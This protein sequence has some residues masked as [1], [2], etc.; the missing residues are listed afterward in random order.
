MSII[1]GI[2]IATPPPEPLNVNITT[3]LLELF[4]RSLAEGKKH[5]AK[6]TDMTSEVRST[7]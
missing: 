6:S 4:E 2:D 1:G 7:K 5:P 3:E